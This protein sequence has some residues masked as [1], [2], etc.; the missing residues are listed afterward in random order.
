[1]INFIRLS[2]VQKVGTF[3]GTPWREYRRTE[4]NDA[5]HVW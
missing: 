5:S 2:R 3:L 1:M 4:V